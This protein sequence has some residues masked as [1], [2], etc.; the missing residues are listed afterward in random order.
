MLNFKKCILE[1]RAEYDLKEIPKYDM[2]YL[3][4]MAFTFC[5]IEFLE[6]K[7]VYSESSVETELCECLDVLLK[8]VY[9]KNTNTTWIDTLESLIDEDT[10]KEY[11]ATYYEPITIWKTNR[12]GTQYPKDIIQPKKSTNK[13]LIVALGL[14]KI[15]SKCEE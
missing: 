8:D 4:T 9:Q 15:I 3:S 12:Y 1:Y 2:L 10:K 5:G 13:F 14:A 6:S 11:Q 7:Q